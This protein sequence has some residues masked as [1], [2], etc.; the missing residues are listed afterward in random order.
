[1]NGHPSVP[2]LLL[3]TN[4]A[5]IRLLCNLSLMFPYCQPWMKFYKWKILDNFMDALYFI[6]IFHPLSSIKQII[7]HAY[8]A[9]EHGWNLMEEMK[10]WMHYILCRKYIYVEMIFFQRTYF[11]LKYHEI[12]SQELW[13]KVHPSINLN[14]WMRL[15]ACSFMEFTWNLMDN[16]NF[17][18]I[19]MDEIKH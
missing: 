16:R 15:H 12:L 10:L 8:L 17:E 3:T 7:L 9:I 2:W 6:L 1:M 14:S 5:T 4:F 18:C 11:T 19:F 13:R